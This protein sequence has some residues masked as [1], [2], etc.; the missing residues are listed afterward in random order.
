VIIQDPRPLRVAYI[1]R[2]IRY[3]LPVPCNKPLPNLLPRARRAAYSRDHGRQG[4]AV[5]RAEPPAA[6][7]LRRRSRI[8]ARRRRRRRGG[9]RDGA[10]PQALRAVV[11]SVE[12]SRPAAS[13]NSSS[14]TPHQRQIKLR[15]ASSLGQ[16]RPASASWKACSGWPA[17]RALRSTQVARLGRRR[18]VLGAVVQ[19]AGLRRR[20][21]R[22]RAASHRL[23][24]RRRRRR[25]ARRV[26][27]A[28]Q[29]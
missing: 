1:F 17:I 20:V 26:A 12:N 4:L 28:A 7:R 21:P 2:N 13:A 23:L 6:H 27:V 9:R 5:I 14:S 15:V 29:A 3:N 25:Q 8:A 22:R 19:R 24:R 18:P 10:H 11:P 16:P